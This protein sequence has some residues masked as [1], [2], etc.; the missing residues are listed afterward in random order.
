YVVTTRFLFLLIS[1]LSSFV[2]SFSPGKSFPF[3]NSSNLAL[4]LLFKLSSS[5]CSSLVL[6]IVDNRSDFAST[7]L[8]PLYIDCIGT[9][10][11]LTPVLFLYVPSAPINS[12]LFIFF[13]IMS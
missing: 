7:N 5:S 4:K 13:G 2:F 1:S 12:S 11:L 8:S 10:N 3:R 9:L 6:G